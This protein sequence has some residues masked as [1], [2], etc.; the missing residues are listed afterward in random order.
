MDDDDEFEREAA[1][2][3][4][5]AA[6]ENSDD[7]APEEAPRAPLRRR[8]RRRAP[9]AA[10]NARPRTVDEDG[11]SDEEPDAAANAAAVEYDEPARAPPAHGRAAARRAAA[12]RSAASSPSRRPTSSRSRRSP[13]RRRRCRGEADA[14]RRPEHLVSDERAHRACSTRPTRADRRANQILRLLDGVAVAPSTH[15]LLRAQVGAR[16]RAAHSAPRRAKAATA[17]VPFATPALPVSGGRKRRRPKGKAKEAAARRGAQVQG[18]GPAQAQGRRRT[19]GEAERR[20]PKAAG[21]PQVERG[22]P[23]AAAPQEQWRRG[24][25]AGA[26]AARPTAPRIQ[27]V[28]RGGRDGGGARGRGARASGETQ[29]QPKC[30]ARGA[31]AAK[32]AGAAESRPRRKTATESRRTRRS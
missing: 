8:R 21:A 11:F 17:H 16:A 26:G 18:A 7:D 32:R 24:A 3:A 6:W 22:G 31:R 4:E 23:G 10:G 29:E 2:D 13:S 15:W 25:G 20:G 30:A 28:F 27:P 1:L 14:R 9:E 5:D 12:L 19:R